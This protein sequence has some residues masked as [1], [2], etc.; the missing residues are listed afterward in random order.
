ME[1][2]GAVGK[3]SLNF[4]Y[5]EVPLFEESSHLELIALQLATLRVLQ[6]PM[7]SAHVTTELYLKYTHLDT[8]REID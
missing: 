6:K 3:K 1:G 7:W 2:H 4:C 5:K 8:S